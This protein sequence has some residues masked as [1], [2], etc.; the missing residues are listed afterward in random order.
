MPATNLSNLSNPLCAL[1]PRNPHLLNQLSLRTRNLAL[2]AALS[3]LV[4][5]QSLTTENQEALE[6]SAHASTE[7]IASTLESVIPVPSESVVEPSVISYDNVWER[8]QSGFELQAHY[9]NPAVASRLSTYTD[10]QRY[11]DLVSERASPFLFAIVE[12]IERRGLP[13]ELALVPIVEST[14]NPNAYSQEH[15][16]GLW[17]FV[18]ATGRSFGLQQ[19]WWYDARRDPQAATVAA[20][21]YLQA[22]YEQFDQDWLLAMAA[23]NTG[24][25]NLRKAIRRS[26]Q[27]GSIDFWS[28]PLASET[29]S[30]IPKIL[31]LATLLSDSTAYGVEMPQI[32]NSQALVTLE[33]GA[34]IDLAQAARL[35]GLEHQELRSFNPG[36]TQ[37]ATHPDHP[38]SLSL[39]P[40]N[41]DQLVAGLANIDEAQWV[42]WDRYQIAPGDTLGGIARKLGTRVD[43]LQSVN[44]L[45]GSQIIAGRSLLIPRSDD[46]NSLFSIPV[47]PQQP[48]VITVPNR[49]T[50][51]RGDNLWSIAR[52]YDLRSKDIANWNQ[53]ALDSLLRPGQQ[54]DLRFANA[55]T[56]GNMDTLLSENKSIY[57]VRPGDSMAK[58]ARAFS[59][60]L[61][62]LLAWNNLSASE[63][64]YPGQ[65]IQVAEEITVN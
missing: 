40:E 4:A 32:A 49:H 12:E 13:M 51:R 56:S 38:Q 36:Y 21:D 61:A 14:F 10:N 35:A 30:H 1:A 47:A 8:L 3:L 11:F 7:A 52:R 54:L 19:D 33:I 37:W 44:Q 27:S 15:A 6:P 17:Q 42:T 31:A 22:L 26:G 60:N 58:I 65:R 39:P 25:G 63:I 43:V 9:D 23:Y 62:D 45:R 41:A 55:D 50:V 57:L 5:C 64:I 18:G 24:D 53:I 20:L 46:A 29:R 16:V 28:L 2:A 48:A 59:T 34:Q